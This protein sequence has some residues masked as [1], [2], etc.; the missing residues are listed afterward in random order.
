MTGEKKKEDKKEIKRQKCQ[1]YTRVMWY[2]RPVSA[3]NVGKKSEFY[4]RK[5]FKVWY[6]S[7]RDF[8][9]IQSNRDFT[10]KYS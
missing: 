8:D 1:I 2:L 9:M 10:D 7:S 5:R 3:F 4:D 6:A